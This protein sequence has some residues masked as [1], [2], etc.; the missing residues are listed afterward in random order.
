MFP[1]NRLPAK[2]TQPYLF[3]SPTF[4]LPTCIILRTMN[5]H[6]TGSN[7]NSNY[8]TIPILLSYG[9][10]TC[11][12]MSWPV[13]LL[14]LLATISHGSATP[15]L[16][17]LSNL[18]TN[19]ARQDLSCT[20]WSVWSCCCR[21]FLIH[22]FHQDLNLLPCLCL[23]FPLPTRRICKHKDERIIFHMKEG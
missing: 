18:S 22:P 12:L 5:S 21:S 10:P 13:L 23:T 14:V 20:L 17:R 2:R 8:F 11:P 7:Y 19:S 4:Q 6:S 3:L 9:L 15:T 16:K 1:T